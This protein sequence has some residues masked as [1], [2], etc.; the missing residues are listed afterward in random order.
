MPSLVRWFVSYRVRS[1]LSQIAC[2]PP[3]PRRFTRPSRAIC[4]TGLIKRAAQQVTIPSERT[5]FTE[6]EGGMSMLDL[7][8]MGFY[9]FVSLIAIGLIVLLSAYRH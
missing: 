7:A 1:S 8:V 9:S 4:L 6:Q 2:P 3:K 5:R